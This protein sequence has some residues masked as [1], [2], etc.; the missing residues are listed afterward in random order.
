[1][2][3]VVPSDIHNVGYDHIDRIYVA[4]AV[5]CKRLQR[6]ACTACPQLNSCDCSKKHS[7]S[8][9][10]RYNMIAEDLSF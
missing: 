3:K 2:M 8:D 7:L 5:K 4:K 6:K 10:L 1:M 9:V